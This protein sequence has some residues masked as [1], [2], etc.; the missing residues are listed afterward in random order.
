MSEFAIAVKVF[1]ALLIFIAFIA[2]C[3]ICSKN[4]LEQADKSHELRMETLVLMLWTALVL[5]AGVIA[6][7]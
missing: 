5:V 1:G 6:I 3:V 4:S 2:F 7:K